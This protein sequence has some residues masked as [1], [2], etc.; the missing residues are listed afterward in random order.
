MELKKLFAVLVSVL[1]IGVVTSRNELLS[2]LDSD[3]IREAA[4]NLSKLPIEGQITFPELARAHDLE[5]TE[6]DVDTEDGYVLKLFRIP[7]D[8]QRPVLL[9]PEFLGSSDSYLLRGTSSLVYALSKIR[10]CDVWVANFRGNFYSRRHKTFNPDEAKFW[11]F[12]LDE[13][14]AYDLPAFIDYIL[15][16][17]KQESL[18]VIAHDEGATS[19]F[20]MGSL[21]PEYNK[22]VK[23]L[24]AMA[25]LAAP[26]GYSNH[27]TASILRLVLSSLQ[28]DELFGRETSLMIIFRSFCAIQTEMTYKMC[29]IFIS[30]LSGDAEYSEMDS[31]FLSIL[32]GH[33]P[34]GTSKKN[35]MHVVQILESKRFA[36]FDYGTATNLQRYSSESPPEY[37]LEK[38]TMPVYLIIAKNDRVSTPGVARILQERLN[39]VGIKHLEYENAHHMDFLWGSPVYIDLVR[40]ILH[41][42]MN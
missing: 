14:G 34:A 39:V 12:S 42:I 5:C 3:D 25:P 38:V 1:N 24:V 6:H 20:V 27:L 35:A 19:L 22:K 4:K 23:L 31:D 37:D 33:Y 13:F 8:S 41:L 15:A 18:R 30:G 36:R 10:R 2:M 40:H 9:V 17:T 29:S 21:R 26:P 28:Q 11:D 16:Q 32:V 7:G